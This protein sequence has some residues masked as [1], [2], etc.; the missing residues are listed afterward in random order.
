MEFIHKYNTIL[1]NIFIFGIKGYSKCATILLRV[2]VKMR[3][4]DLLP[5]WI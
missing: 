1:N 2:Y 4:N 3:T 5:I